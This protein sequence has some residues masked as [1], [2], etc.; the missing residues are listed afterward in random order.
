[1]TSGRGTAIVLLAL[2]GCAT[3]GVPS[4][5]AEPT[6]LASIA[7][8]RRAFEAGRGN[9]RLIVFLDPG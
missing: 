6:R 3:R 2:A 7:P 5:S 9:V 4:L 1:M 8:L